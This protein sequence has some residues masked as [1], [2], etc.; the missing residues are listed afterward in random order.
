M[1]D[2]SRWGVVNCPVGCP[3]GSGGLAHSGGWAV[4]IYTVVITPY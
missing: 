3:V 2:S 4:K 1:D